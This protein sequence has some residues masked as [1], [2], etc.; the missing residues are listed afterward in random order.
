[1]HLLVCNIQWIQEKLVPV[2]NHFP[3]HG[4]VVQFK[5]LKTS[6][7]R[8]LDMQLWLAQHD[9]PIPAL[10]TCSDLQMCQSQCH[11]HHMDGVLDI[12]SFPYHHTTWT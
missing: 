4:A 7:A 6:S 10:W 11:I 1:V 9:N 12:L 8:R 2:F 5:H 3:Y